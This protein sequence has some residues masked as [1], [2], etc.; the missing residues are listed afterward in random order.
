LDIV[1][2]EPKL[3]TAG[4]YAILSRN[5]ISEP[6][7]FH[8]LLANG[9]KTSTKQASQLLGKLAA[10]ANDEKYLRFIV[11]H[12][13][14]NDEVLLQVMANAH[15]SPA[16][17]EQLLTRHKLNGDHLVVALNNRTLTFELKTLRLIAATLIEKTNESRFSSD[18]KVVP[19]AVVEMKKQLE[20]TDS[21]VGSAAAKSYRFKMLCE[22]FKTTYQMANS[23]AMHYLRDK[24]SALR[25]LMVFGGYN[26]ANA[27]EKAVAALSL[28]DRLTVI[29]DDRNPLSVA[30]AR[31]R[32]WFASAKP[33]KYDFGTNSGRLFVSEKAART[34]KEFDALNKSLQ[35]D[36]TITD[37]KTRFHTVTNKAPDVP[38]TI[39]MTE[40]KTTLE[41]KKR[42][43][44]R[45]KSDALDYAIKALNEGTPIDVITFK[46][47]F[48][49]Y[50]KGTFSSKVNQLINE[51]IEQSKSSTP[52]PP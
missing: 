5:D 43:H 39:R 11:E 2:S 48:P 16:I 12:Q 6:K 35:S 24:I 27:I 15:C 3:N 42:N 28:K 13:A 23:P 25:G 18:D 14:C 30:L 41:K 20:K 31:H 22:S 33:P 40:Y 8:E 38:V 49:N 4:I 46:T 1:R 52:K 19:A 51:A 32:H 10:F 44:W 21:F 34:Y 37:F 45:E 47:L 29:V 9:T 17:I 36:P 26:K 7:I 50:A